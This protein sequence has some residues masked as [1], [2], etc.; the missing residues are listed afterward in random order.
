[1][2]E[3]PFDGAQGGWEEAVGGAPPEDEDP[4]RPSTTTRRSPSVA[5]RLEET[6]ERRANPIGHE[7]GQGRFDSTIPEPSVGDDQSGRDM[8]TT[9]NQYLATD[10]RHVP[11]TDTE[12]LRYDTLSGDPLPGLH[13]QSGGFGARPKTG[14]F[15]HRGEALCRQKPPPVTFNRAPTVPSAGMPSWLSATASP[16]AEQVIPSSEKSESAMQSQIN[17][18]NSAVASLMVQLNKQS[19]ETRNPP[20]QQQGAGSQKIPGMSMKLPIIVPTFS[21]TG[22]Q[23]FRRWIRL[24]ERM[25]RACKVTS[26]LDLLQVLDVY[27]AGPAARVFLN[28]QKQ[29]VNT[30]EGMKTQL[31]KQFQSSALVRNASI[32]FMNRVQKPTE[33]I[34]EYATDLFDLAEES[35]P[36]IPSEQIDFLMRD[37]FISGIL[38]DFIQFCEFE[39]C[40]SFKSAVECAEKREERVL[41][42]QAAQKRQP[43]PLV[44]QAKSERPTNFSLASA[45]EIDTYKEELRQSRK[46]LVDTV[47]AT[48]ENAWNSGNT[49]QRGDRGRGEYSSGGG[50]KEEAWG[51]QNAVGVTAQVDPYSLCLAQMAR[52]S[53]QLS[54]LHGEIQDLRMAS[55][56]QTNCIV[57]SEVS[58]DA[59]IISRLLQPEDTVLDGWLPGEEEEALPTSTIHSGPGIFPTK[60]VV[61]QED[62]GTIPVEEL[63]EKKLN[64]RSE[65]EQVT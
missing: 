34:V 16:P 3:P 12:G 2:A 44:E 4:F 59:T 38:P 32:T 15:G 14:L 23:D 48:V 18:L 42:A 17:T 26:S 39:Q 29:G 58:E 1:M 64:M 20:P 33:R 65:G 35:Y 47:R 49:G 53:E 19:A 5:S 11:R 60:S 8:L 61:V 37:R 54:S 51:T 10:Q 21:G 56:H 52:H 31:A 24:F 28:V 62:D 45:A 13:L 9:P 27:L 25:T 43:S 6:A 36:D 22:D 7:F 46:E 50:A 41:S 57:V 30:Y 55:L 63:E 40:A